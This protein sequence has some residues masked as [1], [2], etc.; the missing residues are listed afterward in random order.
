MS[1]ERRVRKLNTKK[2]FIADGVFNAELNA[3]LTK[4]LGVD[5]YT[6]LEIRAT[7]VS[8]EIRIKA[9]NCDQLVE[10]GSRRVREI[11]SLIEKRFNFNEE[12]NKVVLTIRPPEYDKALCAASNVEDLKFK[13]LTGTPV[14]MGVNNIMGRIMRRGAIGCTIIVA[15]KV[16]GQ[17]AKA[18]K[19]S[20]G[21]LISTGQPNKDFVDVG[22]R[23]VHMRQGVLGLKVLIMM[24]LERKV[25]KTVKVMPDY[26]KIHEPKDDNVNDIVP[27]VLFN[28]RSDEQH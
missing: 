1:D 19:Y 28:R 2:K 15:G 5:G 24:S 11:K 6:G 16:R 21:Y 26:V 27:N 13:L 17:R 3:F 8:T 12:D 9:A 25:G 4:V 7:S 10:K 20:A 14:R 23:H 22:M 18:Q